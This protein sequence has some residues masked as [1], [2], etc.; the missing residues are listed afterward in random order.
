[1]AKHVQPGEDIHIA[2]GITGKKEDGGELVITIDSNRER[3]YPEENIEH[4]IWIFERQVNGWFLDQA[5]S[6]LEEQ[7]E[8]NGFVILMIATAYIEGVEQY[9]KGQP[10][11]GNSR[12]FF[13]EGLKRIFGMKSC[14]E[15]KLYD[16]YKELRCS[17]FHNGMTG[18]YIRIHSDYVNPIDLSDSKIIKINQRLFLEKV[19]EDFEQYLTD[20]KDTEKTE[21]RNNFNNWYTLK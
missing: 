4:K 13:E 19:K 6:L 17:L 15:D 11:D 2:P 5:Y 18:R 14:F 20:L 1:M 8:D 7:D 3:L 21:L 16:L 10:S 12:T 9:R